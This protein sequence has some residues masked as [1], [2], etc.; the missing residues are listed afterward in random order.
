M[1]LTDETMISGGPASNIL[2]EAKV[3]VVDLETCAKNYANQKSVI[4]HRVLCAKAEGIDSCQVG[5]FL[6]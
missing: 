5:A 6:Y 4:D 1:V 3:G 2:Q